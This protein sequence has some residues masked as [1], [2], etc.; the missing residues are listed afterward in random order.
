MNFLIPSLYRSKKFYLLIL[1]IIILILFFFVLRNSRERRLISE[2]NIL[3]QKVENF[4]NSNN[5]LPKNL[6]EIGMDEKE[7]DELHYNVLDSSKYIISFGFGVGESIIYH[8]DTR[9]WDDY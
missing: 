1:F 9:K 2:G 3:I 4:K 5:R 8:S 7:N 6:S